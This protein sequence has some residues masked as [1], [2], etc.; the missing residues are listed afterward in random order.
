LLDLADKISK[1]RNDHVFLKKYRGIANTLQ[2]N[3]ILENEKRQTI[4]AAID[5]ELAYLRAD[6]EDKKRDHYTVLKQ[7]NG[8][9]VIRRA[10]LVSN[11]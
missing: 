6:Y 1:R 10:T 2:N 11:K 4:E 9:N 3:C 7:I 8:R 5:K